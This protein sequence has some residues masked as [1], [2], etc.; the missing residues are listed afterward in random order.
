MYPQIAK[1]FEKTSENFYEILWGLVFY[2]SFREIM[3]RYLNIFF[4]DEFKFVNY[5]ESKFCQKLL[6]QSSFDY[7]FRFH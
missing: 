4:L 2:S 5:Y 3:C 6:L 1:I 7:L